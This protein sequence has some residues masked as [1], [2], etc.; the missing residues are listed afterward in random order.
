MKKMSLQQIADDLS[1]S[2]ITVSKV[3]NNKPGVSPSLRKRINQ[4]LAEHNYKKLSNSDSASDGTISNS[5]I[6]IIEKNIAVVATEPG[7]SDF[8]LKIINGISSEIS[9]QHYNLIYNFI[10]KDEAS[11]YIVPNIIQSK[12]VSG[13]VVV[14][15]YDDQAIKMLVDTGLPIVFLDTTPTILAS[16]IKTDI[17][18]LEG[19]KTIYEITKNLISKNCKSIGF[20]GDITYCQTILDRYNGFVR[21]CHENNVFID[22]K[23]CFTKCNGGHFYYPNELQK[24]LRNL[25]DYPDAFVCANDAIAD[26]LIKYLSYNDIHVPRDIAVSGYDNVQLSLLDNSEI[27]TAEVDTVMLGRRLARQVLLRIGYPDAFRETVYVN[28]S[29][30][31]RRSTD[32]KL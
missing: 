30:L 12:S 27:T 14:N 20:I 28:P 29:I 7:F 23:Y 16:N 11:N 9:S 19:E 10:N 8:W 4:K 15:L 25:K 32:I 2:R 6:N 22:S 26:T 13:I 31:Y 17:I 21:A 3:L 18:L 5:P 1:V 24:F